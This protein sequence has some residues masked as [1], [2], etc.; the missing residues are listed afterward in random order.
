MITVKYFE[1]QYQFPLDANIR[2][3]VQ[4]IVMRTGLSEREIMYKSLLCDGVN[5][6][7]YSARTVTP[8]CTSDNM[9]ISLLNEERELVKSELAGNKIEVN[10][11]YIEFQR[12]IRVPTDE[13]VNNLPPGMGKF[14]LTKVA[15]NHYA[16]PMYQSEAA[17]INFHPGC[18]DY[19]MKIIVGNINAIT[20]NLDDPGLS[21]EP[22]NYITKDQPWLDGFKMPENAGT[23]LVRQFVACPLTDPKS[24]EQQLKKKG[25]TKDLCKYI[26]FEFYDKKP[27]PDHILVRRGDQ[28]KM[29]PSDQVFKSI[30]ETPTDA[31]TYTFL[32]KRGRPYMETFASFQLRDGDT[33]EFKLDLVKDCYRGNLFVR[34]LTG[35]HITLTYSKVVT[36]LD[37]KQHIQ[38]VEGIPL[39]QQRLVYSGKQLEDERE[40]R[41]DYKIW[42][43]ST[44]HLVL[45]LRGGGPMKKSTKKS[46]EP[47]HTM[48]L[49]PGG[50]IRQKIYADRTNVN[51]YR[52]L[53]R[54][55]VEIY[56]T[57]VYEILMGKPAPPTPITFET[58][59]ACGLPW[60]K[61]YDNHVPSVKTEENLVSEQKSV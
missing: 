12:T 51:I 18:R 13:T 46:T 60:Y 14:P 4:E 21:Q 53:S 25:I 31:N 52:L 2:E 8:D 45:R 32:S 26:E 40:L 3:S 5:I 34:T 38:R 24:L 50:L 28:V 27:I 11:R 22:Q 35:K 43:D 39:D 47:A 16:F 61:L 42:P 56:D 49:A 44:L 36:V 17:W 29:L 30:K 37:V 7:D 58:Y 59:K 10:G 19:A 15:E 23:D 48:S 41:A 9:L 6:M 1:E 57:S 55:R 54:F 33:L 20:G